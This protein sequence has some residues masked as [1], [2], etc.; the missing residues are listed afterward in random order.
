MNEVEWIVQEILAAR[1]R[2]D[3]ARRCSRCCNGAATTAPQ[4]GVQE[5]L[6]TD[7]TVGQDDAGTFCSVRRP[8]DMLAR[9]S[10]I[11]GKNYECEI[12][13]TCRS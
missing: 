9:H 6:P 8:I 3:N 7:L 13:R 2:S 5:S 10:A 12:G 1:C 11:G 4:Y